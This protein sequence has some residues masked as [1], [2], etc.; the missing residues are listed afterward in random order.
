MEVAALQVDQPLT[1]FVL[2]TRA[3]KV[4]EMS[5]LSKLIFYLR[6]KEPEDQDFKND[7]IL[8]EAIIAKCFQLLSKNKKSNSPMSMLTRKQTESDA[9][10][11]VYS[12]Y[13]YLVHK[14]SYI[15]RNNI[16]QYCKE[17]SGINVGRLTLDIEQRNVIEFM[18]IQL[19]N[20]LHL[21]TKLNY[22]ESELNERN[23]VFFNIMYP[24]RS[25][26][27][28]FDLTYF[29]SHSTIYQNLMSKTHRFDCAK[30]ILDRLSALLGEDKRTFFDDPPEEFKN[31]ENDLR[32]RRTAIAMQMSQQQQQ[33]QNNLNLSQTPNPHDSDSVQIDT[34]TRKEPDV[35][36]NHLSNNSQ[37]QDKDLPHQIVI[38]LEKQPKLCSL[39]IVAFAYLKEIIINM[40]ESQEVVY[41]KAKCQNLIQFVKKMDKLFDEIEKGT[42]KVQEYNQLV[43]NSDEQYEKKLVNSLVVSL[44]R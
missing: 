34:S 19:V 23:R 29:H 5:N 24:F 42:Q 3:Q 35:L 31:D 36:Y 16:L 14:N 20:Q 13:P 33:N 17:M 12:N 7:I 39:D 1:D 28:H 27:N 18:E 15:S 43:W 40:P 30:Q 26:Q 44:P 25:I 2:F 9:I 11:D 8:P 22:H 37:I 10:D 32:E 21:V 41:L 4:K 6:N 38:E